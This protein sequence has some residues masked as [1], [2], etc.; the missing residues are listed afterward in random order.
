MSICPTS[1]VDASVVERSWGLLHSSLPGRE[2]EFYGQNFTW[3][4]LS[5]A[6]GWIHGVGKNIGLAVSSVLVAFCPPLRAVLRRVLTQPG[7]GPTRE[8]I[9]KE[10]FEFWGTAK[11]DG[12]GHEHEKAFVRATW[13]GGMYDGEFDPAPM[14]DL[15]GANGLDS[16]GAVPG[17]RSTDSAPR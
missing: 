13:Q 1:S 11:A 3:R 9:K 17:S 10:K 7:K 14:V 15:I 4:E 16:H 2:D 6:N 8:E 12:D 5:R